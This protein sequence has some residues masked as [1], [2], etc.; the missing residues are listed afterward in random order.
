[1]RRLVDLRFRSSGLRLAAFCV[2]ATGVSACTA[3]S[4]P[5]S[6]TSSSA[7]RSSGP[8]AST[9]VPTVSNS[10]SASSVVPLPTPARGIDLDSATAVA[11][12]EVVA[13]WTLNTTVDNGWY[14][15][16]LAA[17][18]Y[19]TPSYAASIRTHHPSGSPG[20]AWLAWATHDA[21][22]SVTVNVEADPG[23][24]SDTALNAYRNVVATVTPHNMAG[25]VG[26]ADVW[27]TYI[28]LARSSAHAIWQVALTETT[29]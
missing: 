9:T 2:L 19:M 12:A 8:K 29:P 11:V 26:Q 15:G 18:A 24:P 17:T 22:T 16:E 13:T 4:T 27:V 20:A 3:S 25:W 23:G 5:S 28:V 14:A 21:A 7:T 10:G 6:A 1:M